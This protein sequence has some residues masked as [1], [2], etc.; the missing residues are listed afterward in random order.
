MFMS[1]F[2]MVPTTLNILSYLS[3]ISCMDHITCRLSMTKTKRDLIRNEN[4]PAYYKYSTI[5]RLAAGIYG[6]RDSA[7][8]DD[9]AKTANIEWKIVGE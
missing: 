5:S 4:K 8:A 7:Y 3:R 9:S 2:Y 6:C 1:I